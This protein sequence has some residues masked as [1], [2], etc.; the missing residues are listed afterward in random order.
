MT[1]ITF[2]AH[3]RLSSYADTLQ[4]LIRAGV[5]L[6]REARSPAPAKSVTSKAR[7]I[8]MAFW[9]KLVRLH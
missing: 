2:A 8:D 9:R 6:G 4:D 7:P 1:S 3:L 5:V